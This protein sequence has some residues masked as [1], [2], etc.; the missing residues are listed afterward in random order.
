VTK[1]S[2]ST[3]TGVALLVALSAGP[4]SLF[5]QVDPGMEEVIVV[6]PR[7]MPEQERNIGT[8]KVRTGST[9]QAQVSYADL[10]LDRTSDVRLLEK[11][12]EVA[13]NQL[14][15]QL[16]EESP[17]GEPRM[18]VCVRD[19]IEGTKG[20]IEEAVGQPVAW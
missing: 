19:A 3:L 4:A 1:I 14:C 12:I 6:A 9:L 11:R 2:A 13:A 18:S 20:Q 17:I 10:S 15:G 7:V 8:A 5:A 16:A